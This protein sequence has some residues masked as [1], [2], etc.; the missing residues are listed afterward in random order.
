MTQTFLLV[1][2]AA[3]LAPSKESITRP[4]AAFLAWTRERDDHEGITKDARAAITVMVTSNSVKVTPEVSFSFTLNPDLY[5]SMQ[6]YRVTECLAI[7][8][9][10]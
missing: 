10:K 9:I 1:L 8:D 3:T 6:S 5:S 4:A 7:G 2:C